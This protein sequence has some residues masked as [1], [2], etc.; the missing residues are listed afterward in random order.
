MIC[1]PFS[2]FAFS[3][4]HFDSGNKS[5]N[6][7]ETGNYG[8]FLPEVDFGSL[9][10][11]MWQGR[12]RYAKGDQSHFGSPHGRTWQGRQ[13]HAK[14][15]RTILVHLHIVAGRGKGGKGIATG[16]TSHNQHKLTAIKS[17][18]F[19]VRYWAKKG[20][21]LRPQKCKCQ[22]TNKFFQK[23]IKMFKGHSLHPTHQS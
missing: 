23:E 10:G 19:F 16:T 8:Q 6:H 9:H 20:P 3:C 12:Q 4:H 2:R 1:L 21:I 22:S 11:W 15:I 7:P 17:T 5:S 18:N 14:G 13:R